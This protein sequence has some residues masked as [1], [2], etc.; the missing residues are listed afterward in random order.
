MPLFFKLWFAFVVICAIAI[1]GSV[2]CAII[3]VASD[4]S[5]VGRAAGEVVSSFKE[6]TR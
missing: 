3:I 2:A 6:T 1:F 4:P 5:I